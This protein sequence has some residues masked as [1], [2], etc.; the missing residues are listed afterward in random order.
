MEFDSVVREKL[1]RESEEMIMAVFVL[2]LP[3]DG[4]KYHQEQIDDL[5]LVAIS[6]RG[7]VIGV[8]N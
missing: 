1:E 3:T 6:E 5:E 2:S 4:V 8:V 7:S